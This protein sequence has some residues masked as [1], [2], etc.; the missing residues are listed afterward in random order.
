MK[1]HIET[2]TN[3]LLGAAY[4]DKRLEGHEIQ[5]IRGIL[6][7]IHGGDGV[8]GERE[9]QIKQFNPAKFDASAAAVSLGG[10]SSDDKHKLLELISTVNES[11]EVLDLDEDAYL[12]R[13]ASGMGMS[14]DEIKDLTLQIDEDEDWSQFFME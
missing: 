13:V 6:T 2:V 14:D 8:P 1:E 11:D 12:R 10:L 7:K 5:T 4:A 3:L 9:T